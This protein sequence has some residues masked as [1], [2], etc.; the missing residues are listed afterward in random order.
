[1]CHR[2]GAGLADP[3]FRKLMR[4]VEIGHTS[5]ETINRFVRSAVSDKVSLVA[6]DEGAGYQKMRQA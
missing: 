2:L 4:I 6:T 5:A 3:D 1:M